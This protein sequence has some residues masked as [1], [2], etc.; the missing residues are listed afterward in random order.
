MLIDW[1]KQL[2]K[3]TEKDQSGTESSCAYVQAMNN[4]FILCSSELC[5]LGYRAEQEPGVLIS[6]KIKRPSFME[7]FF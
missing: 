1:R 3:L 4:F 7:N 5:Q 6:D 2:L